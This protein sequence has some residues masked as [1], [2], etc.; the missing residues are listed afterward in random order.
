M[1]RWHM[2]WD[3]NRK[4]QQKK[5]I[6]AERRRRFAFEMPSPFCRCR[7]GQKK[8]M[9]YQDSSS[10]CKRRGEREN[11]WPAAA[12][13]RHFSLSVNSDDRNFSSHLLGLAIIFP[14]L[15]SL[16][17]RI[18][19]SILERWKVSRAGWLASTASIKRRHCPISLSLSLFLL[20]PPTTNCAKAAPKTQRETSNSTTTTTKN[21]LFFEERRSKLAAIS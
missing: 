8:K 19:W 4:V 18:D 9:C 17:C 14:F 15:P 2:T 6:S 5:K 13:A 10:A 16:L 7:W 12:S 21:T 20:L 1:Q 3:S 11:E